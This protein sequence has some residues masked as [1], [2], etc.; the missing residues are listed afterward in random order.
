MFRH[1]LHTAANRKLWRLAEPRHNLHHTLQLWKGNFPVHGW[2]HET[3]RCLIFLVWLAAFVGLIS[4]VLMLLR[5][6]PFQ[7]T[8]HGAVG[9]TQALV[10]FDNTSC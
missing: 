7:V 4:L 6:R 2:L 5:P 3:V 10:A 1:L 9:T 8:A